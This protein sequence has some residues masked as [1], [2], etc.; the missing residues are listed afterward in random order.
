M[1]SYSHYYSFSYTVSLFTGIIEGYE[2]RGLKIGDQV[3]FCR[4]NETQ[5]GTIRFIGKTEFASGYWVG[6]ELEKEASDRHDGMVEGTRYFECPPHRGLFILASKLLRNLATH[7]QLCYG[8]ENHAQKWRKGYALSRSQSLQAHNEGKR[9]SLLRSFS[10]N[11]SLS[12]ENV[13]PYILPNSRHD[14][15]SLLGMTIL[16]NHKLGVVKYIGQVEFAEGYWF[17]LEMKEQ[18]GKHDGVVNGK[19]YFKCK[20]GHG[21]MVLPKNVSLLDVNADKLCRLLSS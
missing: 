12:K 2:Y 7:K 1:S 17:G 14:F 20:P 5:Y 8:K 11:H 13:N 4:N 6:I 19:R 16:Y 15:T 10:V 18:K 3:P 21:I 9:S